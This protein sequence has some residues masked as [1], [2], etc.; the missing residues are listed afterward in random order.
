[1]DSE[2]RDK[3]TRKLA[4][5]LARPRAAERIVAALLS[6]EGLLQDTRKRKAAALPGSCE[7]ESTQVAWQRA[8]VALL[9]LRLL[10]YDLT[11]ETWPDPS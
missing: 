3:L 8:E 10:Y 7:A 1:M 2:T 11:F 6:A 9:T 5:T 4:A